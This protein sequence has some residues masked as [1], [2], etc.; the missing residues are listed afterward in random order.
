MLKQGVTTN[1]NSPWVSPVAL[2]AKKDGSTKFC[3]D[4]R[5]LNTITKLASFPLPRVDDSLDLLANIAYF[6]SLD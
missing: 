2:M 5:K 1:S 3:K 4:Y 6:S